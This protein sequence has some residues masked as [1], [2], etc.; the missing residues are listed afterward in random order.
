MLSIDE[1]TP[2]RNSRLLTF[3]KQD[4]VGLLRALGG[5]KSRY[6]IRGLLEADQLFVVLVPQMAAQAAYA[7]AKIHRFDFC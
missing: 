7:I 3:R 4:L 1:R 2:R 6:S 5:L